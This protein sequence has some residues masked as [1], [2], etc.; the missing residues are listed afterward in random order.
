MRRESKYEGR[1]EG[2][3]KRQTATTTT[4]RGS[5]VKHRGLTAFSLPTVTCACLPA[6]CVP[7][8]NSTTKPFRLRVLLLLQMGMMLLV[9]VLVLF[10]T[11]ELL[12]F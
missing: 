8:T 6:W 5:G 10:N 2:N 11:K 3:N 9:L 7:T 1:K 4:I 12:Y